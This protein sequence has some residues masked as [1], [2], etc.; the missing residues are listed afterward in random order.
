MRI[1]IFLKGFFILTLGYLLFASTTYGQDQTIA[2]D[3]L[4]VKSAVLAKNVVEREP[5]DIVQSYDLSESN[6]EAWCFARIYNPKGL[7]TVTFKWYRGDSLHTQI[8]AKIG[9]SKSWRTYSHVQLKEGPWR[10]EIIGP[11]NNILKE[12]RFNVSE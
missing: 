9:K 3:T 5:V 7:L 8:D 10:V 11:D 6:N 2:D 4:Y 12:I 1:H